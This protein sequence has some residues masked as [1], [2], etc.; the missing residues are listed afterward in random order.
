M[1]PSCV[2]FLENKTVL[3]T[4]ASGFLAKVFV[5]RVLRLQPKVRRLYLLVR[6]SDNK[7]AK[8]RLHSEVF[9][10]DLFRVLRKNVG[11]ERLNAL[12]SEKVVPI[13]GD[14]SLN[15]MGVIRDSNFLQDMMQEIDIIVNSA[16]TTRFD[17]R[18]DV[19]LGI[20]TFGPLNILNF[21][22]KCAKP[23]LLLHVSTAYVCGERSG[24]ILEKPFAMGETLNGKNK[25]DIDAEMLLVEQKLKQLKKLGYSEEETKQAMKDLGLKRAKLYGWPNTY[26]F[27][28]AMGEMLLGY[29]RESMPIVIIRPT[30]ITSTFSDPFPGWIEGIKTIDSVIVSFRKG[31]LKCFLVD[32]MAVCDLIPVD[33]VANAMIV[34]AAE[35]S[36]ES[37][38]HTIYHVGSSYQNPV[39]Y[40]QIYEIL[41]RFFLASPLLGRNG[42]PIVPNVKIFP[43]MARF[44]VYTSLRYKLPLQILRLL[45]LIFPSQ[46]GEKYE[47]HNRRFNIAMRMVKLYR[48]YVIF[49]GIFDDRNLERLRIKNEGTGIDKLIDSIK[50]IDWEDYFMNI[51]I[52]GLITHVLEK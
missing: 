11:D 7:A 14:I 44:R 12:I 13:P 21:A 31:L 2:Q 8:Q 48:P 33:M 6:A 27:T 39:M 29:C 4:G 19:A 28:K 50:C 1:E 18:Y 5:E 49:K 45:R 38:S 42:L 15:N 34:T 9:E 20:N 47:V 51:H 46:L 23:Q 40:K 35:H 24:L 36:R 43:T 30:I 52:R 22:K 25:V 16:A 17:E 41:N 3:V 10:K 37:G 32:D 26:V